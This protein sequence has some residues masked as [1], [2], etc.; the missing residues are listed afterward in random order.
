LIEAIG[1]T[2]GNA[3]RDSET[4][5]QLALLEIVQLHSIVSTTSTQKSQQKKEQLTYIR[6]VFAY[7]AR[8][9]SL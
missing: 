5:G 8:L 4:V 6:L 9:P 2:V 1:D 7:L 3:E